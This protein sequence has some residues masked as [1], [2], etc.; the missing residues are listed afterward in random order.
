MASQLDEIEDY[1]TQLEE[2]LRS[3]G[4][5]LPF[6]AEAR[7]SNSKENIEG[8]VKGIER[9]NSGKTQ[10]NF[11]RQR[12]VD[13]QHK[14]L[15]TPRS[16]LS[17][18]LKTGACLKLNLTDKT[19]GLKTGGGMTSPRTELTSRKARV[20]SR[21]A[22]KERRL[23][24]GK[25][26]KPLRHS[27][28]PKPKAAVSK[29]S[30]PRLRSSVRT[31]D[32]V[33]SNSSKKPRGTSKCSDPPFS[34]M[35]MSP[36][37]TPQTCFRTLF[38]KRPQSNCPSKS[39]PLPSN[40]EPT[41]RQANSGLQRRTEPTQRQIRSNLQI[42]DDSNSQLTSRSKEASGGFLSKVCSERLLKPRPSNSH[43]PLKEMTRKDYDKALKTLHDKLHEDWL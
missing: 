43:E 15:S 22:L 18:A 30:S 21:S 29:V 17:L 38:D 23:N 33:S 3:P 13:K 12:I 34:R 8:I 28:G 7:P 9:P 35:L 10:A 14:A 19:Q 16:S 32:S 27:V 5:K 6:M 4:A 36:T 11:L 1:V 39:D 40:A 26:E 42:P 24:D 20:V 37:F 25:E 41:Q 2:V 31:D